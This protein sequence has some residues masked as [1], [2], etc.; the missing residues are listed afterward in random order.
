VRRLI[1]KMMHLLG[2]RTCEEVVAVLHDYFEGTLDPKTR[3]LIDRHFEDCP[4][5]KE[6]C[7]QYAEIIKLGGELR[8]DDIPEEV[9]IR[10]RAALRARAT[11]TPAPGVRS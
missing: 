9:K 1:A 2:K 10:V 6:F 11:C 7:R 3:A 4:D 8:C 5:C